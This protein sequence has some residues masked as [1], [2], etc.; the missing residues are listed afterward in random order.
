MISVGL[1][2]KMPLPHRPYASIFAFIVLLTEASPSLCTQLESTMETEHTRYIW[3][4]GLV[5]S[6]SV[7][8]RDKAGNAGQD[9][10]AAAPCLTQ[11]TTVPPD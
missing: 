7:S 10:W 4:L 3:V 2:S 5:L 8:Q 9:V 1:L 11:E 6:L